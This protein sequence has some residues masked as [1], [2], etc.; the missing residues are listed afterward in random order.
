MFGVGVPA[1]LH[2]IMLKIPI[3]LLFKDVSVV[4]E[5]IAEILGK[6]MCN[7]APIVWLLAREIVRGFSD[8]IRE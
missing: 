5:D 4:L 1:I 6:L 3:I 2:G 8:A 7:L